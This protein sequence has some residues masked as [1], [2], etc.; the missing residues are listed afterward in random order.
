MTAR[1]GARVFS[2]RSRVP[3]S[4]A[5][6]AWR[7]YRRHV[8]ETVCFF[9]RR[10]STAFPRPGKLNR[11]PAEMLLAL[12]AIRGLLECELALADAC[13]AAGAGRV[14]EARDALAR[15]GEFLP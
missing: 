14:V 2:L 11:E 15:A 10:Y 9:E 3:G 7:L 8:E 13:A 6:R 5:W 1:Q 12:D 4:R